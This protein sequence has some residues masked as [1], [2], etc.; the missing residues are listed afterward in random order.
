MGNTINYSPK[1][2]QVEMSVDVAHLFKSGLVFIYFHFSRTRRHSIFKVSVKDVQ[3]N[4]GISA[5][6]DGQECE[7]LHCGAFI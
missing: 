3:K 6:G 1:E 7:H 5:L 4:L 2:I